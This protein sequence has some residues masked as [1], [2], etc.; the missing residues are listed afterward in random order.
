M[1]KVAEQY[2]I[3]VLMYQIATFKDTSTH[4]ISFLA[5]GSLGLEHPARIQFLV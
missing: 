3:H 5:V 2:H 4:L 1:L